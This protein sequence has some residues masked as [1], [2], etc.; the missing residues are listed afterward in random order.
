MF[1][2]VLGVANMMV[3]AL[4]IALDVGEG[5]A[6]AGALFLG[7]LPALFGGLALG[8]VAHRTRAWSIGPRFAIIGIPALGFVVMCGTVL[9]ELSRYIPFAFVPTMTAVAILERCTRVARP[10]PDASPACGEQSH[11]LTG[12]PGCMQ[13]RAPLVERLDPVALGLLLALA[14]LLVVSI[15]MHGGAYELPEHAQ[16]HDPDMCTHVHGIAPGGAAVFAVGL[17]PA[18]LTGALLGRI[19]HSCRAWPRWAR[20]L[21]LTPPPLAVVAALGAATGLYN[22]VALASVPTLAATLWLEAATRDATTLPAARAV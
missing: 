13:S 21:L 9:L 7:G 17:V 20:W 16:F 8:A 15:G 1:G 22:Y 6:F 11:A 4:G 19:A 5:G 2:A 18:L 3:I 12:C 10:L 14:N